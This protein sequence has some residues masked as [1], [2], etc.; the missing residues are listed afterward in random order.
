MLQIDPK[1]R[2]SAREALEAHYLAPYHDPADEPVSTERLD[3]DFLE[4]ELP[5]DVWKTV[6]YSE[7]LNYHESA[8]EGS[9]AMTSQL[10]VMDLS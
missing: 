8:N 4:A 2:C 5:A 9:A 1:K 10:G 6:M 7:V 3:W